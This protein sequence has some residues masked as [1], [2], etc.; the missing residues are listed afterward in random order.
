MWKQEKTF[1]HRLTARAITYY[2]SKQVNYNPWNEALKREVR[3]L[4]LEAAQCLELLEARTDGDSL[5][6]IKEN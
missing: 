2:G 6:L 1:Q 4:N 5:E 3:G